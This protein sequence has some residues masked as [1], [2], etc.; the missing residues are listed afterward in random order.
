MCITLASKHIFRGE[1]KK[2]Q[3]FKQMFIHETGF[4]MWNNLILVYYK[5]TLVYNPHAHIR[6]HPYRI[7]SLLH[8]YIWNG[9][10][11]KL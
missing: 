7:I 5:H 3:S 6:T 4:P 9:P 2:S 8:P 11:L 10:W 1:K